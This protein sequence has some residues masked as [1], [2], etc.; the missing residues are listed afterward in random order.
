MDSTPITCKQISKWTKS[1][2]VLSRV[3]KYC[4]LGWPS[5]VTNDILPYYR[6]RL[7]LSV[8]QDCILWGYR[9]L[10]PSE[11]RK[12]L[13]RELHSC[14]MGSTRMK[15]LARGYFWWPG[16]DE[17]IEQISASCSF[18]LLHRNNLLSLT[19]TTLAQ[20]TYR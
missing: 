3:L 2:S 13:L 15:Q 9:I 20:I 5:S 11:G 12:S 18:C 1:D 17:D 19:F 8:Q 14:H 10:I 7:K 6:K 16:L 4:V